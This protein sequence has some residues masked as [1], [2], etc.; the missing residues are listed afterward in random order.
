MRKTFWMSTMAVL[1][2]L[3][4]LAPAQAAPRFYE[5]I[6]MATASAI[7]RRDGGVVLAF[8]REMV[9]STATTASAT[10][11]AKNA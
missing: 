11:A 5:G 2:A 1:L 4:S 9:K 3:G 7:E 6:P 8:L 10:R